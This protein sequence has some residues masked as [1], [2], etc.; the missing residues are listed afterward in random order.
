MALALC[1]RQPWASL[2]IG[3]WK[4]IESRRWRI[5][6]RGPLLIHA[7]RRLD[8]E[9]FALARKLGIE[10]GDVELPSGGVIGR[11]DVV[12]C[13]RDSGSPW[14]EPGCWHWQLT[15]AEPL[16]FAPARGRLGLFHINEGSM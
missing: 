6:H 2:I 3:A 13:V 1:V 5:L 12:G 9:G 10:L 7:G 15:D 8:P 14:A 11:V 16:P 4:D